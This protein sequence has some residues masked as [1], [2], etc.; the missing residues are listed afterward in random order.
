MLESLGPG[1]G[2]GDEIFHRLFLAEAECGLGDKA[3]ARARLPWLRRA[4]AR[5][6]VGRA[7]IARLATRIDST[8]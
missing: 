5:W 6:P 1:D 2:A 8:G 4:V 7:R 3:A